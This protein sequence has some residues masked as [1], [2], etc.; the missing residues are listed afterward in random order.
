MK[1]S[2]TKRIT[3]RGK[4]ITKVSVPMEPKVLEETVECSYSYIPE[5]ERTYIRGREWQVERV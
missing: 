1:F 4:R 3:V 2:E 5:C